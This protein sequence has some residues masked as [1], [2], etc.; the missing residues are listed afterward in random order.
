MLCIFQHAMFDYRRVPLSNCSAFCKSP[1]FRETRW[2]VKLAKTSSSFLPRKEI[3]CDCQYHRLAKVSPTIM[4]SVNLDVWC[5]WW[6]KYRDII[7][8][9]LNRSAQQL[10]I[11]HGKTSLQMWIG[12]WKWWFQPQE[13]GCFLPHSTWDLVSENGVTLQIIFLM[14]IVR[15]IHTNSCFS[16]VA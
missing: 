9:K 15:I 10:C 8:M 4:N 12:T 16:V 11:F 1:C 2:M 5:V 14:G 6:P 7:Q 13:S 3:S